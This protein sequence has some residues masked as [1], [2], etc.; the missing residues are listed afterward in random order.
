MVDTLIMEMEFGAMRYDI[1]N[2]KV[3]NINIPAKKYHMTN[4]EHLTRLINDRVGA[5]QSTLP[6]KT[7]PKIFFIEVVNCFSVCFN[8][9]PMEGVIFTNLGPCSIVSGIKPD[10][11]YIFNYI[12]RSTSLIQWKYIHK[13]S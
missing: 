6:F 10:F 12:K 3:P 7:A 9:V 2:T 13:G 8:D 1:N 11:K 5:L 4:I